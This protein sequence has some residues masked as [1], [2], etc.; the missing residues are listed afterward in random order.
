MAREAPRRA[1]FHSPLEYFSD[2]C[3]SQAFSTGVSRGTFWNKMKE[4]RTCGGGK[5]TGR[6]VIAPLLQVGKPRPRGRETEPG[7]GLNRAFFPLPRAEVGRGEMCSQ[8]SRGPTA[9]KVW[10]PCFSRAW[11]EEPAETHH[12]ITNLQDLQNS[13]QTIH[14]LF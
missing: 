6:S 5:T 13:F 2:K 1:R 10:C 11:K 4:E 3:W 9:G 8:T 14:Y 12:F 7:L